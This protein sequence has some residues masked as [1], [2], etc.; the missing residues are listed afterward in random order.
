MFTFDSINI[1]PMFL[2]VLKR[3]RTECS[4]EYGYR[5]LIFNKKNIFFNITCIFHALIQINTK[6]AKINMNKNIYG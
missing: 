4:C 5:F 2:S 3:N 6:K 1:L